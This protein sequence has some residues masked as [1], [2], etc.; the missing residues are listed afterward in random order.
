L[1]QTD[2]DEEFDYEAKHFRVVCAVCDEE[3]GDHRPYF[4]QE[5]LKR[6]PNHM[7]YYVLRRLITSDIYTVKI[8]FE[9]FMFYIPM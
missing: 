2:Y 6:H 7:K 8:I 5:H 3:L 1:T 9:A 4:A